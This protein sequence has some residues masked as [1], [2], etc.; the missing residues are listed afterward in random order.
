M[1]QQAGPGRHLVGGCP[2]SQSVPRHHPPRLP[3]NRPGSGDAPRPSLLSSRPLHASSG[4]STWQATPWVVSPVGVAGAPCSWQG[5][6]C[7][8]HRAAQQWGRC[9]G[10]PGR[11]AGGADL[12][13]AGAA[14]VRQSPG[15][16]LHSHVLPA[17]GAVKPGRAVAD[18]PTPQRAGTGPPLAQG[19]E[20]QGPACWARL[21]WGAGGRGWLAG[22]P[23]SYEL[24]GTDLESGMGP[25]WHQLLT[26]QGPQPLRG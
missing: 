17:R 4:R 12:V 9:G 23:G 26:T 22:L 21:P 18:I 13:E 2:P 10:R 15:L 16:W 24:G 5:E 7:R 19:L 20:A 6:G 25:G 1:S 14:M 8:A 3:S 11:A